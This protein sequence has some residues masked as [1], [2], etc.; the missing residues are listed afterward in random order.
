MNIESEVPAEQEAIAP[1]A[2]VA[3]CLDNSAR[4][5]HLGK[6]SDAV[7]ELENA[8]AAARA[9]PYQIEFQ[10][11]IRLGM[12]LSDLY[13]SLNR[14]QDG[15]DLLAAEVAFAEKISGIMQATG[16]PAQKRSA[17]S[18]YLQVRDR[19]TQVALI[20]EIAPEI[21]VKTWINGEPVTLQRRG[22]ESCCWNSGRPGASHV[23]RCFRS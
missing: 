17:T 20:G 1:Q 16:T 3:A 9:T 14:I 22:A 12:M 8:L 21:S 19:A 2:Y 18:G 10:T 11:R 4:L 15:R 5:Q 7:A 13:L 23:R 6:L